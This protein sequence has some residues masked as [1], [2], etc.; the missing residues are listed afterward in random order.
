MIYFAVF[1]SSALLFEIGKY[2]KS[3]YVKK[4]LNVIALFLPILLSAFRGIEVG[5]DNE[6][7]GYPT[8]VVA[9]SYQSFADFI[10][11][12][13][14]ESGFLLLEYVG[15][16]VFNSF[17]FVLGTIQF[18]INYCVYKTIIESGLE[19]NLSV[20][21]LIFY[22]L[23]YGGS[24]NVMRQN[25]A[26]A[27]VLLSIVYLNK[28]KYVRSLIL[29]IIA[30]TFHTSAGLAVVFFAIYFVMENDVL[31]KAV[32]IINVLLGVIMYFM[33]EPIFRFIFNYVPIWNTNYAD[34]FIYNSSGERNE[35]TLILSALALFIMYIVCKR[36]DNRWN[37]FLLCMSV[38]NLVYQPM[39]E[40]VSV[41]TR[42]LIY[43]QY[44]WILI[45]SKVEEFIKVRIENEKKYN[46]I[47][48]IFVLFFFI[49]WYYAV[50]IN[51]SNNIIP[52]KLFN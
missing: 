33:W 48:W 35:T 34:Y 24:L 39:T 45:F 13:G 14:M 19:K 11:Y 31:Y 9:Q 21:M 8:F 1:I 51:N 3:R 22:F 40:Q 49:C 50:I 37:R 27:L 28:S 4:T 26:A 17:P 36:N 46:V 30:M 18:V 10:G 6:L 32:N 5:R 25:M 44:F 20:C 15:C 52:Y 2:T 29:L 42:L 12:D 38:I 7:Y 43:P 41:L 23:L 47:N 16:H